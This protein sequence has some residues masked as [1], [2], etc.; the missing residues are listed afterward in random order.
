MNARPPDPGLHWFA[1]RGWRPFPFQREL[2][3]AAAAGES[4]L[5]HAG[6]GT[7]KT[8]AAWFAAI[9]RGLLTVPPAGAS[10]RVLWI[11]PMRAL[12]A[13]TAAALQAPVADLAPG[14]E[15]GLRTGDTSSAQRR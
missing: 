12:A 6:T 7:G 11:T 4:G 10:L 13:D 5:L 2:W 3:R 1:E 15:V 14:W 9:R 8:Y